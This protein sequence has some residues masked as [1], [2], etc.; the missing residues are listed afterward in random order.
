MLKQL[1]ELFISVVTMV[2]RLQRLEQ[3]VEKQSGRTNELAELV[4]RLTREQQYAA[5]RE[6]YER[7]LLLQELKSVCSKRSCRSRHLLPLRLA[8]MNRKSEARR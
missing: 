4:Y 8:M 1:Y 7:K 3:T 5:E 6:A 2:Q